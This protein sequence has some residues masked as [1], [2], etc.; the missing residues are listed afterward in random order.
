MGDAGPD[1]FYAVVA[2]YPP[3][4][5]HLVHD[6]GSFLLGLGAT[7]G[8]AL[9]VSDALLV[10]LSGNAIAGMAHF[11]SHIVDREVGGQPTDPL[12]IGLFALLLLAL[13]V[14]RAASVGRLRA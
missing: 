14:W 3:Y 1:G 11:V 9:A 5:R 12:T 8:L 2:N 13:A 6:L 7:L 4:N 10:A